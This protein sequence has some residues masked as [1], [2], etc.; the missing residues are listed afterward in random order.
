MNMW[1]DTFGSV[2][3][4]TTGTSSG[5]FLSQSRQVR[6]FDGPSSSATGGPEKQ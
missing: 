3:E 5:N 6:D 4:R 2:G 1:T